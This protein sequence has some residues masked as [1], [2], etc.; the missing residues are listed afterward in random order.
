MSK[1]EEITPEYDHITLKE[2]L[3]LPESERQIP[4]DQMPM[5]SIYPK[6]G[7]ETHPTNL[8]LTEFHLVGGIAK[9]HFENWIIT[10]QGGIQG[11]IEAQTMRITASQATGRK[12]PLLATMGLSPGGVTCGKATK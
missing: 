6:I 7:G 8:T 5:F 11:G 10:I 1:Q 4:K 12:E 9:I 2:Q 3:A